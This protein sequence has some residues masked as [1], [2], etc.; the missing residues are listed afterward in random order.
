MRWAR[1]ICAIEI[2]SP[3]VWR[4][5]PRREGTILAFF[6]PWGV[7]PFCHEI[8]ERG[9]LMTLV[10]L[11]SKWNACS[12]M[13]HSATLPAELGLLTTLSNG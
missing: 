4:F 10:V 7:R 12:L 6:K 5:T 1:R 2:H 13:F 9:S 3:A 11:N 8:C